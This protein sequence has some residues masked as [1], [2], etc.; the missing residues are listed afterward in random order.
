MCISA[1]VHKCILLYVHIC[2]YCCMYVYSWG[3]TKG[4]HRCRYAR[5]SG[6]R[7]RGIRV[8]PDIRVWHDIGLYC[9]IRV[10]PDMGIYPD[11]V[12]PGTGVVPDLA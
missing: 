5:T 8:H 10:Y 7:Y 4:K 9:D 1:D 11:I 6:T 2:I 12:F 3:A